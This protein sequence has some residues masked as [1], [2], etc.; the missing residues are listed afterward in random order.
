M[1]SEFKRQIKA[2]LAGPPVKALPPTPLF[3]K[4][5]EPDSCRLCRFQLAKDFIGFQGHFEGRPVLPAL[6]QVLMTQ[7][8]AELIGGRE[9]FMESIAQ[10]KFLSLVE[11]E[12]SLLVYAQ[13]PADMGAGEWR[14]HLRAL[15]AG[16]ENEAA[17]IRLRISPA[18]AVNHG[19]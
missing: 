10:A 17:F 12:S 18:E 2:A 13:V 7:V 15:K 9:V 14:F 4:N 8:S 1:S 6:A 19:L 11:P 16:A 5:P 3:I